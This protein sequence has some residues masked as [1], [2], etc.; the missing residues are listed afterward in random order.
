LK[1]KKGDQ[2]EKRERFAGDISIKGHLQINPCILISEKR[3]IQGA[4]KRFSL[5]L[6]E[7]QWVS[8]Q[9]F[10]SITNK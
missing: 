8:R 1:R 10:N 9:L 2:L 7:E 4:N 5:R 6:N 3:A